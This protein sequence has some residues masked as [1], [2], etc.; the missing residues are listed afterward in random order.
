MG[1][2]LSLS[3]ISPWS[4]T[5]YSD[6]D[7]V[8]LL[9]RSSNSDPL[10][11]LRQIKQG[12]SPLLGTLAA[13][14]SKDAENSDVLFVSHAY[15]RLLE[16][17]PNDG[18]LESRTKSLETGEISRAELVESLMSSPDLQRQL[19]HKRPG[20]QAELA[21]IGAVNAL[22]VDFIQR[23]LHPNRL[24]PPLMMRRI[25]GEPFSDI[26][27]RC[28]ELTGR[29]I[30]TKL[31]HDAGLK[32]ESHILD[33]G[34]GCGRIAIP[35]TESIDL[36]GSYYGLE[37]VRAMVNW[38]HRKIT[39]KFPQFHF[40]HCDVYNKFYNPKGKERDESYQFP[41]NANQFDLIIAT[42]IFTHLQPAAAQN[43][44]RQCARVMKSD[45]ILFMTCF[46]I[47]NGDHSSDG[48]LQ[49]TNPLEGGAFAAKAS[50]PEC[51]AAYPIQWFLERFEE[52]HFAFVPPVRWGSWAG[53]ASAYSGQD[54]LIFRKRESG[55]TAI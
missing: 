27:G 8:R 19:T 45:G 52:S 14:L 21:S 43:Y 50:T 34:S 37:A 55:V 18:E 7:L 33:I 54:V 29:H 10:P 32:G 16:R 39:P 36:S 24:L 1:K 23:I 47:E 4:G 6:K 20:T 26:Y 12:R 35:L 48:N 53:K 5:G 41:F 42:S 2:R 28:F 17:K 44:I 25:V 22:L 49:F 11:A 13:L 51:A 15:E 38:C 30:Q 40:I 31:V 9:T 46:L 3:W